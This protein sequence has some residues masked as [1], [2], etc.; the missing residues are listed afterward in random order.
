MQRGPLGAKKEGK[1]EETGKDDHGKGDSFNKM[2]RRLIRQVDMLAFKWS[3]WH[4]H[5]ACRFSNSK[6]LM[7]FLDSRGKLLLTLIKS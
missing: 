3:G 2:H 6:A 5:K 7:L 1:K 4:I